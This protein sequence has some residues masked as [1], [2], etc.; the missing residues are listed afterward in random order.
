[1]LVSKDNI[2]RYETKIGASERYRVN[3]KTSETHQDRGLRNKEHGMSMTLLGAW[4]G[5][6]RSHTSATCQAEST[7]DKH[8]F[9]AEICDVF[10]EVY[11]IWYLIETHT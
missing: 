5:E 9:Q 6:Q 10:L 8:S 2:Y 4:N 3:L 1:M 7:L 11:R